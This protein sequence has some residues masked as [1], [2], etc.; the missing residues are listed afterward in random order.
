[1]LGRTLPG[2]PAVTELVLA[3]S[4]PHRRQLLSRLGLDFE[5][6]A[7]D[8]DETPL[9]GECAENLVAR[10]S[11]AKARAVARQYPGAVIVGSDQV[12][13]VPKKKTS[14]IL[15]K[16]DD[17]SSAIEQLSLLS[18]RQIRFLTGVCVLD[19]RGGDALEIE[20]TR[21][22]FRTLTRPEIE[23]Y[24]HREQ[25]YGCAGSFRSER[26]G[27]TLVETIRSDDPNALIGL[28]L[29]RLCRMLRQA[30]LDPLRPEPD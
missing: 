28:P 29:I 17:Y 21:V 22:S 8:L 27:I 13:V 18:G 15:G 24:V 6:V 25:P 19:S 1:M 11:V 20:E 3:S 16:P 12:A 4:S 9:P 30:G 26:L 14:V 5:A 23:A 10:L 2:L 7:P